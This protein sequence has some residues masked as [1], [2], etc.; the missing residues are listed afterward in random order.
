MATEKKVQ[1]RPWSGSRWKV[2]LNRNR[3]EKVL[4]AKGGDSGGYP[5]H[6]PYH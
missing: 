6:V 3:V 2:T 5:D 1:M 4:E